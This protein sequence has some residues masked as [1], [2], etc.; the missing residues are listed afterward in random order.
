MKLLANAALANVEV[1]KVSVGVAAPNEDAA[2]AFA[3]DK[4][5]IDASLGACDVAVADI[6]ARR[7]RRLT[8]NIVYDVTVFVS[9]LRINA[10]TLTASLEN[11]EAEGIAVIATETDPIAELRMTPGLD[12][13]LVDIFVS[14]A[15]AAVG[16][17]V[18]LNAAKAALSP[19]PPPW[20]PPPS[21]PP[22]PPS[23]P[24]PV[25]FVAED[26][27]SASRISA[28][29]TRVLVTAFAAF[30]CIGARP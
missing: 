10:T 27:K 4:M 14:D 20:P 24:P 26:Y 6:D 12:G 11:L 23:P 2:C 30:A 21:P 13:A 15:Q 5:K 16:A 3:F 1:N 9:A 25:V 29:S 28:V 18:N 22:P 7:R 8:Q 17:A 19:P